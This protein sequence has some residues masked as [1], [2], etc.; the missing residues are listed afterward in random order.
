[1]ID[2]VLVIPKDL[3][4]EYKVKIHEL[5]EAENVSY[6]TSIERL[7]REEGLRQGFQ[8]GVKS[9]EKIMK[10]KGLDQNT[11]NTIREI[12]DLSKKA[13]EQEV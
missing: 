7:G 13:L 8:K 1:M 6:I 11:K 10:S 5:E 3:E 12:L 4:L 2:W 9:V